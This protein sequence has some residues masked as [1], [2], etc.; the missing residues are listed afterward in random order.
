MDLPQALLM[1]LHLL[2]PVYWLGGDLGTFLSGQVLKNPKFT[3]EERL[4][5]L[6][7]L[8][9]CDMGPRTALIL[10]FPTGFSLA[11][12]RGWLAAPVPSMLL[13]WVAGLAWLAIAWVIHLRHGPAAN[14]YRKVD[15]AIRYAV[16]TALLAAGISGLAGAV[17]LP[18]FIAI[19]L[20]LLAAGVALGLIVR[21]QLA[22]LFPAVG[23]LRT[24]GA[25]PEVDKAIA[26]VLSRTQISVMAIWIVV[27]LAALTG[28]AKP[29]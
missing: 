13:A 8:L 14:S 6:R 1:M 18:K 27:L 4:L 7:I 29:L 21:R 16:L 2:I 19:K 24:R 9:D 23:T 5:A 11:L 17:A 12:T 15:Y 28:I 25:G 20:L 26:G 3:A 22:P 10:A